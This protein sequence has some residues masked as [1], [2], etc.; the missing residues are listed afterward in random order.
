MCT[1]TKNL[2]SRNETPNFQD[3]EFIAAH[4]AET[5][6]FYYPRAIDPTGGHYQFL[7][8][9]GT[10]YDRDTRHLVSST[11]YVFIW[12][13]AWRRFGDAH[14][15]GETKRA[16]DFLRMR[17]ATPQTGGYAGL[18]SWRDAPS[19]SAGRD[20]SLLRPSPLSCLPY[21]HG[22][23]AGITRLPPLVARN[24]GSDRTPFWE[25]GNELYADEAGPDLE[26]A[27]VSRPKRQHACLQALIAA[28]EATGENNFSTAP[29]R[30]RARS[31]NA[32]RHWRTA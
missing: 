6:R 12:A 25:A 21:A 4:I 27:T 30:S 20:Q 26:A 3:A 8:D 23:R 13:N 28:Y 5:L 31:P 24:L 16:L 15:L 32:R 19:A 1:R 2:A 10:V 14:H 11:R 22:L 9:D 7:L 18:L 17:I 29:N